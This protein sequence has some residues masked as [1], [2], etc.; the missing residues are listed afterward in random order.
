M[1]KMEKYKEQYSKYLNQLKEEISLYENEDDLWKLS[2]DLKNTPGNL[3]IHVCGNLK[4]NFGAVLLNNSYVRDRDS[5][6]ARKNVPRGEIIK[7]IE[8]TKEIV[9]EALNKLSRDDLNKPFPGKVY[10]DEGTIGDLILRISLH[11]A[12]HLGQINYHR[13]ILT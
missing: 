10:G 5:E 11:L 3:A 9:S 7:E 4:F 8:E 1:N 2:G 13:R 6:F 12:Y